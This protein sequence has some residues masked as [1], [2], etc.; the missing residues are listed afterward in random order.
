[1][2]DAEAGHIK[3]R[4]RSFIRYS[5]R[6]ERALA[7]MYGTSV[8]NIRAIRRTALPAHPARL[9]AAR[10]RDPATVDA[11]VRGTVTKTYVPASELEPVK[12]IGHEHED[13]RHDLEHLRVEGGAELP[14]PLR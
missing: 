1:M 4:A 10:R 11:M 14:L 2:R 7:A 5:S 6:T 9:A 12:P 8:A 3:R 13:A